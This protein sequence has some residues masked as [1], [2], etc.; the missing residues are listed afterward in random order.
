M[1]TREEKA[2][3]CRG[4]GGIRKCSCLPS[5]L[6]FSQRIIFQREKRQNFNYGTQK[7]T[8]FWCRFTPKT[9]GRDL[10]P[11]TCVCF[12]SSLLQQKLRILC[13]NPGHILDWPT[14]PNQTEKGT[15]PKG[16]HGPLQQTT[17]TFLF[18]VEFERLPEI[19]GG[20]DRPLPEKK[21]SGGIVTPCECPV[22]W[23]FMHKARE[24]HFL[25]FSKQITQK[26][27]LSL[28]F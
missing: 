13:V 12:L 17:L 14:H 27:Q 16:C 20:F 28:T 8:V 7:E 11:E 2:V 22:G 24:H 26:E 18:P 5:Q 3:K 1:G 4:D 6:F 23:Y 10:S 15:N 21:L 9:T 25:S 19:F